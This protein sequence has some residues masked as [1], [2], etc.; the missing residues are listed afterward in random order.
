M[1]KSPL[2]RPLSHSPCRRYRKPCTREENLHTV[3]LKHWY[4]PRRQASQVE[5]DKRRQA[6]LVEAAD[7]GG[8]LTERGIT[9]YM[10]LLGRCKFARRKQFPCEVFFLAW[11]T[12]FF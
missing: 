9:L 8:F 7:E 2:S 5:E 12:A 3:L 10:L 6:Q 1:R 4:I 11:A